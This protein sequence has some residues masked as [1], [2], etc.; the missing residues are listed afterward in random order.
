MDVVLD[1]DGTITAKDSISC[2]GEFGVSHQQ[3]RRRHDLT[4][5]WE[6]I[7][8][9]YVADHK[10][11]VSAY[12]PAEADRLTHDEE[13]AFLHSL[14][15]VDVKSLG[16]VADSKLFEGCTA[17]DLY[18]AGQ[19]AVRIGKVA[20][21]KGF[22]EFVA[23]M[24]GAGA[25]L[26]ILS[27]NWSAA[28]IRGVLSQCGAV[29]ID[30]VVSN[31]ITADGKIGSLGDGAEAGTPMMTSLHK[32]KALQARSTAS[33]GDDETKPKT[34]V[35]FGD[36]TT[37]L[38]CLLAA[39]IGIVMANDENSSLL[40]ALSRLGFDI[41]HALDVSRSQQ[42]GPTTVG[43][44]RRLAWATSFTEVLESGILTPTE[45]CNS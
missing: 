2:L 19:E 26:S 9:E 8:S 37:D 45:T 35:Y 5:T 24:R 42:K 28:F 16:R 21:R 17:D 11:H 36:S 25:S 31:E 14:Q 6:R 12:S 40:R 27:V 38:E 18:A 13:R 30:D 1:F 22:A 23:A 15:H 3:K 4:S 34:T 39:D 44:R 29:V 7:V 43:N 33:A 20:P 32:L 41:P 10:T